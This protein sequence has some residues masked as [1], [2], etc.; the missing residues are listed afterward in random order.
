VAVFLWAGCPPCHPTKIAKGLKNTPRQTEKWPV[1]CRMGHKTQTPMTVPSGLKQRLI[2]LRSMWQM[3]V[4]HIVSSCPQTKME[5]G[6]QHFHSA[7]DVAVQC[8]AFYIGL[9]TATNNCPC[10][11]WPTLLLIVISCPQTKLKGRFSD[12]MMLL[13]S[14]WRRGVM[15]SVVRR[16]NEVTVHWAQLVLGWVTIFGRVYH[17]GV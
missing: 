3:T 12:L 15:A 5:G 1:L 13:F 4:C 10:G 11:K 2:I 6:L 16:M 8:S 9:K 17:H 14:G 7:D